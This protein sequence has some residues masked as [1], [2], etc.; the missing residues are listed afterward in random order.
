MVCFLFLWNHMNRGKKLFSNIVFVLISFI[1]FAG[2]SL[3]IS[4]VFIDWRDEWIEL[5]N[6]SPDTFSWTISL[7][8]VASKNLSFDI[9]VTPKWIIVITDILD[10]FTNLWNYIQNAWISLTD[11]N[12]LQIALLKWTEVLDVFEVT[13]EQVVSSDNKQASFYKHGNIGSLSIAMH[14]IVNAQN[15]AAGINASPFISHI[16]VPVVEMPVEE[17]PTLP[18]IDCSSVDFSVEGLLKSLY[19]NIP[20]PIEDN[21]ELP[22]PQIPVEDIGDLKLDIIEFNALENE[23]IPEYVLFKS[24]GFFSWSLQFSGFWIGSAFFETSLSLSTWE[25]ILLSKNLLTGYIGKSIIY[26]WMNLKNT[27]ESLDILY[28]WLVKNHIEYS[29]LQKYMANILSSGFVY[30]GLSWSSLITSRQISEPVVR[31]DSLSPDLKFSVSHDYF[32][33]DPSFSSRVTTNW[34][35]LYRWCSWEIALTGSSVVNFEFLYWSNIFHSTSLSFPVTDEVDIPESLYISEIYPQDHEVLGQY[36]E[37]YSPDWYS[38]Q[39]SFKGLGRSAASLDYNVFISPWGYLVLSEKSPN[40]NLYYLTATGISLTD[41]GEEISLVG[42]DGQVLDKLSYLVSTSWK[43][44][45]RSSY[46]PISEALLLSSP[47]PWYDYKQALK[48]SLVSCDVYF[49]TTAPFYFGS[50]INLMARLWNSTLSNTSRYSCLWRTDSGVWSDQCNPSY[51]TFSSIGLRNL[52]LEIFEGDSLICSTSTTINY[53]EKGLWQSFVYSTN[54]SANNGIAKI[55]SVLPNPSWAD[56]ANEQISLY[57][58]WLEYIELEYK[59]SKKR[60]VLDKIVSGTWDYS[61]AFW[62]L[63]SGDCILL[64]HNWQVLDTMCYKKARD[65]EVIMK[66]NEIDSAVLSLLDQLWLSFEEWQI[67]IVYEDAQLLCNSTELTWWNMSDISK[68]QKQI[69]KLKSAA[70]K[71][72]LT[73]ADLKKKYSDIKKDLSSI[74]KEVKSKEKSL[75]SLEKKFASLNKKFAKSTFSLDSQKKK[76]KIQQD[77]FSAFKI[78]S[79]EKYNT[80][81]KKLADQKSKQEKLYSNQKEINS[82][83][84][85]FIK[86]LDSAIQKNVKSFY[87][88]EQLYKDFAAYENSIKTVQKTWFLNDIIYLSNDFDN[89][90]YILR[91]H[92]PPKYYWDLLL[93]RLYNTLS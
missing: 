67:C 45:N 2:N 87:L 54:S 24:L 70:E 72:K 8:G 23:L 84:K 59:K 7:Q 56:V 4:E 15:V 58:E 11:T 63:N 44:F 38:W 49:Q 34:S 5:F 78:E 64:R 90:H 75:S 85:N 37:L 42:Q 50:S 14:N 13:K 31:L 68:S 55:V 92:V 79:K 30:N 60:I 39:V 36:I 25:Q 27:W 3:T 41:S 51:A 93:K 76:Y 17:E 6:E 19:C 33:Q 77:K 83:Q 29:M 46:S 82:I 43:S 35:I 61:G 10:Q 16:T 88:D 53:P 74:K 48:N 18:E 21:E 9:N 26:S 52:S 1:P 47:S 66:D 12:A 69:E 32:C 89:L 62:F 80:M 65:S 86:F 40:F 57:I 20:V 28:R 73:I 71:N 22:A 81:K 91:G